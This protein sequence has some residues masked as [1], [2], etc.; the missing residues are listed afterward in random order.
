MTTADSTTP[1]HSHTVNF[2]DDEERGVLAAIVGGTLAA[3][4]QIRKWYQKRLSLT[5]KNV[6]LFCQA[7]L[8]VVA[9]PGCPLHCLVG[10]CLL[11]GLPLPSIQNVDSCVVSQAPGC[12]SNG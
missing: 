10:D 5:S 3:A 8:S 4:E 2:E 1:P 12:A 7:H 6:N 11:V 9:R